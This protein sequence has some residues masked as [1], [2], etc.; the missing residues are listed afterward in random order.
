MVALVVVGLFLSRQPTSQ[1]Q[2]TITATNEFSL[3]CNTLVNYIN[4]NMTYGDNAGI[5]NQVIVAELKANN[6]L[7]LYQIKG[8]KNNT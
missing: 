3:S 6:Y 7:Q 1:A 5:Y 8:C 2:T 4:T